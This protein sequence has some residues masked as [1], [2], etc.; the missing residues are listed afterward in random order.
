MKR[1]CPYCNKE[2]VTYPTKIKRGWTLFC[3]TLCFSL[4]N[5]FKVR[6]TCTVCG[7]E[8]IV[9]KQAIKNSGAKYCSRE[10]MWVGQKG[11]KKLAIQGDKHS[12]WKGGLSV[13]LYPL[14][15][16]DELKEKIRKRDNYNCQVCGLIDEEHILLYGYHLNVHHI[17]YVKENCYESNLISLCGQ[18]HGRTNYNREKWTLKLNKLLN[19]IRRIA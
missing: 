10:C 18:C 1:Q 11:K 8:F 17:D 4:S 19:K 2:Y 3:S 9:K 16:N 7:K 14:A 12:N 15:F 6:R 5:G 13:E